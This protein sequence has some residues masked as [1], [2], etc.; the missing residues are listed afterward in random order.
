MEQNSIILG[1]DPGLQNT[2]WGIIKKFQQEIKYTDCGAI[3]SNTHSRMEDRLFK[4]FHSICE[5]TIKYDVNDVA[6]EKVFV[7]KNPQTSEKLIMAR[8]AAFIAISKSGLYINEYCPNEVKKNITGSGH[9][10]KLHMQTMIQKILKIQPK[11]WSADAADALAIAICH[12][13]TNHYL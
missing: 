8:A 2:G 11:K 9:A 7:N 1:I 10:S 6:I 13:F 4:I 12:A 3:K 5:L